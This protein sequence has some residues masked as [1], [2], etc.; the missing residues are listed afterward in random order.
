MRQQ[1]KVEILLMKKR[2]R[3]SMLSYT[4]QAVGKQVHKEGDHKAIS[5]PWRLSL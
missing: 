1:R 5:P 4:D 3:L 2:L